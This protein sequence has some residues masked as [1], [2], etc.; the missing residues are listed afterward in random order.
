MPPALARRASSAAVP[1]LLRRLTVR[2]RFVSAALA[3]SLITASS[4]LAQTKHPEFSGIYPHL[5]FFNNENE[6]GTGAVV[7]WAGRLWAI[8]YAPH[9]PEGSTD[10]LYEITPDLQ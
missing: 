1:T 5:A 8:T 3:V 2:G 10:K 7:P 6:C 9:K 4:V